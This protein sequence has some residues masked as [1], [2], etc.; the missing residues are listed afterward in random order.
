MI[1]SYC[2]VLDIVM[3]LDFVATWDSFWNWIFEIINVNKIEVFFFFFEIE[4]LHV[5][6]FQESKLL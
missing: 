6:E 5:D 2:L 3:E 1:F 4:S